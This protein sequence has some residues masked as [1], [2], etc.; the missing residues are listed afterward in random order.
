MQL[1][2]VECTANSANRPY[3]RNIKRAFSMK[4]DTVGVAHTRYDALATTFIRCY[5]GI[6]HILNSSSSS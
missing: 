5:S 3:A 4:D 2:L 6:V 1:E